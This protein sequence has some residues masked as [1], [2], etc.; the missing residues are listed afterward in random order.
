MIRFLAMISL[1]LGMGFLGACSSSNQEVPKKQN[2]SVQ[3][4]NRP[5]S[6]EGSAGLGAMIP[7]YQD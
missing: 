4:H 7:Q 1:A 5:A 6:W 2:L 3:P